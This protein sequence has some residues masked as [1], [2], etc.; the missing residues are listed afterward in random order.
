MKTFMK[1]MKPDLQKKFIR[2]SEILQEEYPD[3]GIDYVKH[4]KSFIESNIWID[5]L[6]ARSQL[7]PDRP[8]TTLCHLDPWFNNMLFNYAGNGHAE[9]TEKV[10]LLDFQLSAD[11]NPGNDLTYFLLTSTTP[12][13]RVQHLDSV[14]H[15]YHETLLRIVKESGVIDFSYPFPELMIDYELGLNTGPMLIL[16]ALPMM[17]NLGPILQNVFAA[18]NNNKWCNM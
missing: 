15:H 13:F 1:M 16:F 3:N 5:D 10:L 4:A 8:F 14:L 6:R 7:V 11:T 2:I 17:L 18:P 9:I 12:A